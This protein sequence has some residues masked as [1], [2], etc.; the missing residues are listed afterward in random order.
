MGRRQRDQQKEKS[1]DRRRGN[2]NQRRRGS[3]GM[4]AYGP[5]D[6]RDNRRA[7][8]EAIVDAIDSGGRIPAELVIGY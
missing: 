7:L 5:E 4:A 2:R 6:I 3:G 1:D 8:D